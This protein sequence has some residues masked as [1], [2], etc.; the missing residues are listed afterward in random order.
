MQIE[1]PLLRTVDG[2]KEY[3]QLRSA[4][5]VLEQSRCDTREQYN[6]WIK[7]GPQRTLSGRTPP[8]QDPEFIRRAFVLKAAADAGDKER[9]NF[10]VR[11]K[12]GRNF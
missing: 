12:D 6:E 8:W 10:L 5:E 11:E 3:G 4:Y 2:I 1:W 7:A 9:V